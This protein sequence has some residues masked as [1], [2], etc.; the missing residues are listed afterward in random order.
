MTASVDPAMANEG[1]VRT[2]SR[3]GYVLSLFP[4]YDETFI[5]REMKA[6]KDKSNVAF[7]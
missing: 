7:S 2:V 5:L 3:V 1:E 6:L 4:C